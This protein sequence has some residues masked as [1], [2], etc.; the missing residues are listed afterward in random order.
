MK[1]QYKK[2]ISLDLLHQYFND[3]ICKE[4][5]VFPSQQT[6]FLINSFGWIMRP[7]ET[8]FNLYARIVPET[9]PAELFT[10]VSTDSFKLVFLLSI[11]NPILFNIT[12]LP[13]INPRNQV[14]YLS[15]LRDEQVGGKKLLGDQIAGSALGTG[16]RLI[17]NYTLNYEFT[18]AVNSA[19]FTLT[20]IF[21][22]NY[23]FEGQSF[24]LPKPTDQTKV[25]QIDLTKVEPLPFGRYRLSDNHGG[26]MD[27]YFDTSLIGERIFAVIELY[28]DTLSFTNPSV[29]NVP[30]DY[31]YI[32]NNTINDKGRYAIQFESK[33]VDWQYTCIKKP[34]NTSNGINLNNLTLTS[35]IGF[36]TAPVMVDGKAVFRSTNPVALSEAQ[37]SVQLNNN[38]TKILDLPNPDRRHQLLEDGTSQYIEMNIYV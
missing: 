6:T 5:Y 25:Y 27:F 26:H 28:S 3:D 18:T 36:P 13:S 21:N 12:D 10:S 23:T 15:N 4:F 14:F 24:T 37:Q 35:A 31:Q 29:N 11:N 2:I 20:D 34:E 38:G 19:S 30:G 8:G 17:T 1:I 16:I 7:E 22:N 9:N 33:T 32:V